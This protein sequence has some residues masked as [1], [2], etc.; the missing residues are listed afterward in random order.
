MTDRWRRPY[1]LGPFTILI[2]AFIAFGLGFLAL[3]TLQILSS[4]PPGTSDQLAP[5]AGVWLF[6]GT[7]LAFAWR[8]FSAGVY[9]STRGIRIRNITSTKTLAWSEIAFIYL[10]DLKIP[11]LGNWPTSPRAIWI[12]PNDGP[13]IQTVLNDQS[14]EYLGRRPA[15][16]NAYEQLVHAHRQAT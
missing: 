11:I 7:F 12:M 2:G 1:R 14:A 4:G 5:L 6:M 3:L 8:M 15:F 16:R 13:P 9:V 10:D